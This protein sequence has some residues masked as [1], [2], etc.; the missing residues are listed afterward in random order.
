M[1][2]R[3]SYLTVKNKEDQNLPL[4]ERLQKAVTP[5]YNKPYED[6]L[7][8]KLKNVK[9]LLKVFAD[10]IDQINPDLRPF[11]KFNRVRRGGHVRTIN[12]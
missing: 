5:F 12:F 8:E 7:V 11:I 2:K 9:H 10:D 3:I 6:Q 4:N 1:L